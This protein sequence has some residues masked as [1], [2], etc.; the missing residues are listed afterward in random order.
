M[1]QQRLTGR[2]KWFNKKSGYGFISVCGDSDYKEKE[3]F[4]H[5]SAVSGKDDQYKYLVQGEYVEF[6][7]SNVESNT[8]HKVQ[9]SN[10]RGVNGGKLLCETRNENRTLNPRFRPRPQG[11]NGSNFRTRNNRSSRGSESADNSNQS[12]RN[13]V[14]ESSTA[15]ENA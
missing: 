7:L 1:S 11:A 2:V 8:D 6:T 13:N 10:I 3:I 5:F 4:A 12:N 9:S 14:S 15:Q